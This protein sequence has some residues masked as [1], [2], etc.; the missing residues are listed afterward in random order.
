MLIRWQCDE[1]RKREG[2]RGG[3]RTEREEMREK[4][5]PNATDFYGSGLPLAF[6]VPV[7]L[8]STLS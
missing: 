1:G 5:P 7:C 6:E 3:K 2:G 8:F 4:F